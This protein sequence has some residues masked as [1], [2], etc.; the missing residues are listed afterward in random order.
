MVTNTVGLRWFLLVVVGRL[1]YLI[2]K[3]YAHNV[4]VSTKYFICDTDCAATNGNIVTYVILN[5]IAWF[6]PVY[7]Q[8]WLFIITA[9]TAIGAAAAVATYRTPCTALELLLLAPAIPAG[10]TA[11][12]GVPA[13]EGTPTFA[14]WCCR[15]Q[16][17]LGTSLSRMR[18]LWSFTSSLDSEPCR[19]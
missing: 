6:R 1:F 2:F 13:V 14:A 11:E 18:L 15:I 10:L 19:G 8:P 3:S 17:C 4:V 16:G 12:A 7:T 5:R 9:P